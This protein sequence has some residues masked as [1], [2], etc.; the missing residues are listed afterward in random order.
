MPYEPIKHPTETKQEASEEPANTTLPSSNEIDEESPRSKVK[1][2][3]LRWASTGI[4][5]V[6]YRRWT[7]IAARLFPED[8]KG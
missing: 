5:R 2:S 1:F 6:L 3:G 4:L 8:S 7:R